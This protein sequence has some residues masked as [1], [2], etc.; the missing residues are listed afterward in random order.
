MPRAPFLTIL[1]ILLNP[2]RALKVAPVL[3]PVV[4]LYTWNAVAHGLSA[5]RTGISLLESL[6]FGMWGNT[7]HSMILSILL[8]TSVAVV[9]YLFLST[10]ER[11]RTTE[12]VTISLYPG[13]LYHSIRLF[14]VAVTSTVL[15]ILVCYL[16][17]PGAS[18]Y[19]KI[20]YGTSLADWLLFHF[21]I[22]ISVYAIFGWRLKPLAIFSTLFFSYFFP[23][24]VELT[25]G[26]N[27]V[28]S[29]SAVN[30][31]L[32]FIYNLLFTYPYQEVF[33]DQHTF[34][35]H[36]FFSR[37]LLFVLLSAGIAVVFL[38]VRAYRS[39]DTKG[40]NGRILRSAGGFA[41]GAVVIALIG[42]HEVNKPFSAFQDLNQAIVGTRLVEVRKLTSDVT[43]W[44]E[45]LSVGVLSW[46][47]RI[48]ATNWMAKITTDLKFAPPLPRRAFLGFPPGAKRV[49]CTEPVGR[50]PVLCRHLRDILEVQFSEP[51]LTHLRVEYEVP[52]LAMTQHGRV[53]WNLG[54]PRFPFILS[55]RI[56]L[57][58]GPTAIILNEPMAYPSGFIPS[59]GNAA[60]LSFNRVTHLLGI[61]QKEAAR[62]THRYLKEQIEKKNNCLSSIAARFVLEVRPPLDQPL[63]GIYLSCP[64]IPKRS[65]PLILSGNLHALSTIW[66][67]PLIHSGG[68]SLLVTSAPLYVHTVSPLP[69]LRVSVIGVQKLPEE[70]V[71]S[72]EKFFSYLNILIE[73]ENMEEPTYEVWLWMG[74]LEATFLTR[75][76]WST[77]LFPY[78]CKEATKSVRDAEGRPLILTPHHHMFLCFR[79]LVESG[80]LTEEEAERG[81]L[82]WLIPTSRANFFT[83]LRTYRKLR[84][85]R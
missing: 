50:K 32:Q 36:L 41:A 30:I 46:D 5:Q 71:R 65:T 16:G 22:G 12:L 78:W 14:S 80:V 61:D 82:E 64:I 72:I 81:I 10:D 39:P 44:I 1:I 47:I 56:E 55:D 19:Q 48:D 60:G 57:L 66:S 20:A 59:P 3:I 68:I 26:P 37:S 73:G 67:P 45:Q 11:F 43:S 33:Q 8:Y 23:M 17:F 79:A 34:F 52:R 74:P 42:L 2:L 31:T 83:L 49:K 7:P 63:G 40:R 58:Q 51:F 15:L 28:G 75:R 69:P 35:M 54:D 9:V 76:N 38:V 27:E 84:A 53:L 77:H 70:R 29:G 4:A 6:M 62:A 85:S 21:I 24:V 25:G 18:T 13:A